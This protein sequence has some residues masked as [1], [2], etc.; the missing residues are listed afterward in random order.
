ME[1]VLQDDSLSFV[2]HNLSVIETWASSTVKNIEHS[3]E[4]TVGM[5]R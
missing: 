4:T 2:E 3:V 1:N 5:S